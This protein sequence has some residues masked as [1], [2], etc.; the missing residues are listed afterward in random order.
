MFDEG[1]VIILLADLR[2]YHH[3]SVIGGSGLTEL[4][5]LTITR[6]EVV[7]TP[8]GEPSGALTFGE[9]C[10]RPVAFLA[11]HGYGHT[12]APHRVNYAANLWA[13]RHAGATSIVAVASVGGIRADLDPGVLLVPDQIIDYTWGERAPSSRAPTKR[14]T[15]STLPNPSMRRFAGVC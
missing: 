4:A 9:L 7:R 10:G 15:I 6:R 14:S 13:L 12:I 11:R 3:V 5:N 1:R 8:Y 2:G